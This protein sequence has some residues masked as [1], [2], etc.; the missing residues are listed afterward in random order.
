MSRSMEY[1]STKYLAHNNLFE[2]ILFYYTPQYSYISY[3]AQKMAEQQ[4]KL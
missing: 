4:H 2:C 1:D 3:A